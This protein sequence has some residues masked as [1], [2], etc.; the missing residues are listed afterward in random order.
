MRDDRN[1]LAVLERFFGPNPSPDLPQVGVE[2]LQGG[3]LSGAAVWRVRG[4]GGEYALKRTPLQAAESDTLG[5]RWAMTRLAADTVPFVPEPCPTAA[6]EPFTTTAE[7]VW[8]LT[9]WAPGR[10]VL[11]ADS[12]PED[13]SAALGAVSE[14][15]AVWRGLQLSL[16]P[17]PS[18]ATRFAR[19]KELSEAP[20]RTRGEIVWSGAPA[21]LLGLDSPLQ[22]AARVALGLVGPWTLQKF[23]LHPVLIDLRA[24]HVLL[25]AGRVTGI[26]DFDTLSIDAAAVDFARMIGSAAGENPLAWR[27]WRSAIAGTPGVP[28]V[29]ETIRVIPALV[30]GGDVLAAANWVRWIAEGWTPPAGSEALA[31]QR[32]NRLADRVKAVAQ[33]QVI[34]AA[35]WGD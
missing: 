17:S 20:P 35:V 3:G 27:R 25:D 6:G 15:H 7:G 10:A 13:L 2:R 32:I 23:V 12:P 8:R 24:E 11:G 4:Y 5:W 28:A 31:I 22:S 33:G 29:E 1:A 18:I 30:A 9:R 14:L 19:L 26:V 21:S 34:S 16:G